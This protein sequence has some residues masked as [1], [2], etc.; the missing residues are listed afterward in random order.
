MKKIS[1]VLILVLAVAFSIC[2]MAFGS[3]EEYAKIDKDGVV[4][5]NDYDEALFVLNRDCYV[6]YVSTTID[7]TSVE[8]HGVRGRIKLD[9]F[10]ISSANLVPN[11]TNPYHTANYAIT[12]VDTDL[13]SKPAT[14]ATSSAN[15]PASTQVFPIGKYTNNGVEYVY[16]S[17]SVSG[18][19]PITGAIRAS[20]LTRNGIITPPQNAQNPGSGSTTPDINEDPNGD[21]S[22]LITP[23]APENN[24]V[25]ILLIVGICVPALIIVYLIFKPVKPTSNRYAS[26]NPR[27]R[28]DYEDFE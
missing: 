28:D 14:G 18:G 3:S 25:R 7:Y 10:N 12:A 22:E 19:T 21:K 24:L 2:P 1:L 13:L 6:K 9:D 16:V 15:I 17:Y 23:Q 4:F 11:I 5:Y 26:D 27:R 8:Y 20:H